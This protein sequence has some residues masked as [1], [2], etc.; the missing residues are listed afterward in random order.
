MCVLYWQDVS[1]YEAAQDLDYVDMVLH[2][3]LRLHP[4]AP[5]YAL[6]MSTGRKIAERGK[7]SATRGG[8]G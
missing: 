5:M 2:E 3:S 1:A 4:P 6:A 8:G 7:F